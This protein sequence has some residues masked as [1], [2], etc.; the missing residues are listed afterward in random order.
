MLAK[1]VSCFFDFVCLSRELFLSLRFSLHA[2]HLSFPPHYRR[3]ARIFCG[4]GG[5][6]GGEGG[7]VSQKPGP[8]NERFE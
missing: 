1:P 4:G 3:V 8:N 7:C 6:G 5:G 2:L